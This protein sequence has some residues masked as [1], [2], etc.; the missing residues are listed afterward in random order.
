[1]R[2]STDV[3]SCYIMHRAFYSHVSSCVLRQ[4]STHTSSNHPTHCGSIPV[5]LAP[6]IIPITYHS[7]HRG[8]IPLTCYYS[9]YRGFH[10]HIIIYTPRQHSTHILLS[11]VSSVS[12]T[13]PPTQC[14]S[15]PRTQYYPMHCSIE[16]STHTVHH[17]AHCG[18]IPLTL[19][20]II[21]KSIPL[22][23]HYVHGN[24]IPLTCY[25]L[26]HRVFYSHTTSINEK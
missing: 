24:D 16:H 21:L 3:I 9:M 26:M 8:V 18:N 17:F 5:S 2:H 23:Y 4:H 19:F 1:M 6:S 13:Y 25:Y 20:V 22:A 12:H 14:G 7:A 15:I 10:A 11:H